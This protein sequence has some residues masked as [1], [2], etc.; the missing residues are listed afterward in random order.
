MKRS[1]TPLLVAFMLVFVSFSTHLQAEAQPNATWQAGERL[2]YAVNWGWLKAGEAEL[3]FENQGETYQLTARAWTTIAVAKLTE[4]FQATGLN[5]PAGLVSKKY[6]QQQ[7]ENSYHAHKVLEFGDGNRTVTYSRLKRDHIEP[8]T[9]EI[10]SD[11][12]DMLTLLYH[13]RQNTIGFETPTTPLHVVTLGDIL[14]V[15]MEI[16]EP[17]FMKVTTLQKN[18]FLVRRIRPR[19]EG[20]KAQWEIFVTNDAEM[21]PVQINVSFKFGTFKARLTSIDAPSKVPSFL[22]LTG[23]IF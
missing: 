7:K 3:A 18:K 11:A 13:L 14:P 4:H 23:S 22:P 21:R 12:K 9:Y 19:I 17:F 6:V 2:H 1:F 20:S 16:S 15:T 5:T 10:P 8:F